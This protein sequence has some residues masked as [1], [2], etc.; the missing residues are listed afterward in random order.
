MEKTDNFDFLT[1][2]IK[3]NRL[4]NHREELEI[5]KQYIEEHKNDPKPDDN[6]KNNL[7]AFKTEIKN[8]EM[9]IKCIEQF[10]KSKTVPKIF[11]ADKYFNEDEIEQN[12]EST[13]E[14]YPENKEISLYE[15]NQGG[16]PEFVVKQRSTIST[17]YFMAWILGLIDKGMGNY[18]KQ[19]IVREYDKTRVIVRLHDEDGLPVDII[20]S[21][22]RPKGDEKRPLWLVMLDKAACVIM[23]RNRFEFAEAGYIAGAGRQNAKII[24]N[25][26]WYQISADQLNKKTLPFKKGCFTKKHISW[27]SESVGAALVFGKYSCNESQIKKINKDCSTKLDFLRYCLQK[28]ILIAASTNDDVCGIPKNRVVYF[29]KIV[30]KGMDPNFPD[31]YIEV[32]ESYR[33]IRK[34]RF[35]D[36]NKF[37][38][39]YAINL[40]DLKEKK[41]NEDKNSD[42]EQ[43]GNTKIDK[44]DNNLCDNKNNNLHSEINL[45]YNE[46]MINNFEEEL[47]MQSN[48][49]SESNF[50]NNQDKDVD[51]S[52]F[53]DLNNLNLENQLKQS[54]NRLDKIIKATKSIRDE[55]KKIENPAKE[56]ETVFHTGTDDHGDIIRFMNGPMSE[57][58]E[59]DENK[60]NVVDVSDGK[61]LF[62]GTQQGILNNINNI[63]QT[64]KE[65]Y[66]KRQEKLRDL[67][68]NLVR[69]QAC[70][71]MQ[72]NGLNF[73]TNN[74]L[75]SFN[76]V[77]ITWNDGSNG[78]VNLT[79]GFKQLIDDTLADLANNDQYNQNTIS[80]AIKKAMTKQI[81]QQIQNWNRWSDGPTTD[82]FVN[83]WSSALSYVLCSGIFKTDLDLSLKKD[84][85]VVLTHDCNIKKD[86]DPKKDL[87]RLTGD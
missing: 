19:N 33:G 2:D 12:Q 31:G 17:C 43:L 67:I 20:V 52:T 11:V 27:S 34:I 72:S 86:L 38:S 10:N 35:D 47:K 77:E 39:L 28:K 51:L 44:N 1:G 21:K 83:C 41:L 63:R 66:N 81:L 69:P 70:Q 80:Q 14:L 48:N 46:N 50:F 87:V 40:P 56:N 26:D 45:C 71:S 85:K 57:I 30:E 37:S 62:S 25:V 84:F 82:N 22:T 54:F 18:I 15:T 29:S 59:W 4:K 5:K 74:G 24:D 61:I 49:I 79:F 8:Y 36:L 65:K 73:D 13:E 16:T 75:I 78:Q 32:I 53:I 76:G 42:E 7:E 3:D 58:V 55:R 60:I 9:R 6:V 64:L 23:N 68:Y